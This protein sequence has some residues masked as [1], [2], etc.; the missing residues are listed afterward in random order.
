MPFTQPTAEA[1]V[2]T[3]A[4]QIPQQRRFGQPGQTGWFKPVDHNGD[5][6]LITPKSV[7]EVT[8]PAQ[9]PGDQP[10]VIEQLTADIAILDGP[11]AGTVLKGVFVEQT[12]LV[13]AGKRA[14]DND[15][16]TLGRIRRVAQSRVKDQY[17]NWQAIEQAVKDSNGHFKDYAWVLENFTPED[18]S[19]A[20]AY[21]AGNTPTPT[22]PPVA[23][24][25]DWA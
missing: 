8:K 9:K 13:K 15:E 11:R 20:E 22:V 25:G 21:L 2:Q 10:R 24:T 3:P 6:V 12:S 7:R 1:P 14:L 19:V 4:A 5:L 23:P 16:E 17:P 18:A